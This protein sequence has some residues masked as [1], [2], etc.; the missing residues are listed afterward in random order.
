[1]S[2]F[3]VLLLDHKFMESSSHD[4]LVLGV[5]VSTLYCWTKLIINNTWTRTVAFGNRII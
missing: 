5:S 3:S 1:M 2:P 4:S